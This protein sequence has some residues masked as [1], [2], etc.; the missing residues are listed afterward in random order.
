[1]PYDKALIIIIGYSDVGYLTM[2]TV[3]SKLNKRCS[4]IK[5]SHFKEPY[6]IFYR[7]N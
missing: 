4:D 2:L 3:L 1:M 6:K 5:I 7:N